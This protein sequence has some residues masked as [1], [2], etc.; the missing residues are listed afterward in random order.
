MDGYS[1][2][3]K[4]R[5][6][7]GESATSDFISTQLSYD[8]IYEAVLEFVK[9]TVLL[10]TT[11]SITTIADTQT[12][13]INPDYLTLYLRDIRSQYNP[14]YLKYNDGTTDTFIQ[15]KA[16]ESIIFDNN[17]TSKSPPD[18]FTV[19]EQTQ[20]SLIS[21]TASSNGA[22]NTPYT[23]ECYLY[24]VSSTS[25]FANVAVGDR[26]RNETD[27]SEGYV[28]VKDS[29]TKLTCAMLGGTDND[30]DSSD[31][32]VIFPQQRYKLYFDPATSD[33]SHTITLYYIQKPI[34]VY[35]YNRRYPLNQI[36]ELPIIQYAAFL[37]KYRD[38]EP[39]YGDSLFKHFELIC[40]QN[41]MVTRNA[42]E[43][44]GFRVNMKKHAF[45]DG[46]YR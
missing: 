36:Y 10:T 22:I 27:G 44:R 39:N 8:Y 17:T 1:L 37:Y 24:D 14:Y 46:S 26:I 11:Q 43:K 41:N 5:E 32:Y 6:M 20:L 16:Y 45:P 23:G 15:Q 4:L 28:I 35:S 7:L 12:Y 40:R 38:R 19:V 31:S 18:Y 3:R 42:K 21:G 9:R 30:F 25:K 29:N 2:Q 34:P 13:N 33:A